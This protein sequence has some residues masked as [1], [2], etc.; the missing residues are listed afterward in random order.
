MQVDWRILE[1]DDGAVIQLIYVGDQ[2]VPLEVS[3]SIVGQRQISQFVYR[4]NA[5]I[6]GIPD[7]LLTPQESNVV[8]AVS[9][10]MLGAIVVV[11]WITFRKSIAT[12]KTTA[13][14]VVV[15]VILAFMS[16]AG[17]YAVWV[18]IH[19]WRISQPFGF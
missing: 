16:L 10:L 9:L 1:K 3:G 4:R 17:L 7:R 12:A 8:Y 2:E 15:G 6:L 18:M 14:T 13:S 5:D 11:P 19:A